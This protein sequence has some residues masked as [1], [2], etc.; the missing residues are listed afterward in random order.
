MASSKV[1]KEFKD[2]EK[3]FRK[4]VTKEKYQER[5]EAKRTLTPQVFKK[6]ESGRLKPAEIAKLLQGAKK[7]DGSPFTLKDIQKFDEARRG[8]VK[9]L[10][11]GVKGAPV[12]QLLSSCWP[13]D[14]KRARSEIGTAMLYRV[15]GNELSFRTPAGPDSEEKNHHV[16]VRLE[17]WQ[18]Y[19]TG[20]QECIAVA[21]TSATGRISFD[22]D[23]GRHQ[24]WFRYLATIGGYALKPFETAF[25]KI[26]NPGLGGACCKHAIR[27]LTTLQSPILHKILSKE[28]DKQSK[29]IGFGDDKKATRFL[30]KEDLAK[31]E[32]IGEQKIV[33]KK[34]LEKEWRAYQ[35]AVKGIEKKLKEP[36]TKKK[37]KELIAMKEELE[38]EKLKRYASE[39]VA[40]KEISKRK[41][42]EEERRQFKKDKAIDKMAT[43]LAVKIYRD[44]MKRDDAIKS[45]SKET[46]ID[47]KEANEMAKQINV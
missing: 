6:L 22:C 34:Q 37:I 23:C 18:D 33:S 20:G 5:R 3:E 41:Q 14:L 2:F 28:A 46:G 38:T 9:T 19:L 25:P 40:K 7:A 47:L 42:L 32:S 27:V 16:R 43:A 24:Y 30:T 31:I 12:A 1:V 21:R 29:T 26:R 13:A 35:K 45:Y 11:S 4:I 17:E 44:K 15:S 10:K 36:E 39:T 8:A